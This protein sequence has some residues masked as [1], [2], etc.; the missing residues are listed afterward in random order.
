VSLPIFL[1]T[2]PAGALADILDPRRFLLA[3]ESGIIVLAILFAT[4]VVFDCA[5][6][7]SLLLTI[8]LL[9][10]G[11]SLTAPAWLS[12]APQL[13]RREELDAASAANSVGYN[14]ARAVGPAIGG[15]VIATLGIAA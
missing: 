3:V 6:P 11:L 12:L 10:A 1:I 7:V 15:F 13:V 4:L 2:L 9:S 5:T 14:I 8:F